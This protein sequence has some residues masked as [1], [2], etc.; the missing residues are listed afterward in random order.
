MDTS[1]VEVVCQSLLPSFLPS[2]LLVCKH[3]IKE[4]ELITENKPFSTIKE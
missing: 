1:S 2:F 4:T 3:N